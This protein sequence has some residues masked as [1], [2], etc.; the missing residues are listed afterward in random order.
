MAV[1]IHSSWMRELVSWSLVKAIE[2]PD[3]DW[4]GWEQFQFD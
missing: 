1:N 3:V 2:D 4:E